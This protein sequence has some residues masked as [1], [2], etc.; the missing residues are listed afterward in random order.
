MCWS[1]PWRGNCC[2]LGNHTQV[3]RRVGDDGYDGYDDDDGGDGDD[4]AAILA[5]ILR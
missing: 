5:I 2:Y 3:R 4:T 1:Q